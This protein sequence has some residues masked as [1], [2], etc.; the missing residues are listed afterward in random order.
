MVRVKIC[1]ITNWPDARL[2]IDWGADAL[3]FNFYP[4]SP[5]C[6]SP[7]QAW[8]LI[9]KLPPFVEAVGV[10]VNWSPAA[11][12]AVARAVRL[13]AVQLHG[14][15]SPEAM[16]KISAARPVI[17]AFRVRNGFRPS[18]LSRYRGAAAFLLDGF[19]TRLPGG[20]GTSFD[21]RVARRAARYGPIILAGGLGPEN[22]IEAIESAHPFGLDVC[23][24][25]EAKPGKKD[26]ARVRAFMRAVE[27]ANADRADGQP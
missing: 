9:R 23:S 21:W 24:G 12:Q 13:T 26:A 11:V 10:F 8:A 22:A 2:A 4:P 15:E 14:E 6:V 16:K 19:S 18:A 1:G 27:I 5:R 7:A 3:G 17:K 20:T 25:V